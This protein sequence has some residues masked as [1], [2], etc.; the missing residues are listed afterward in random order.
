MRAPR[1]LLRPLASAVLGLGLGLGLLGPVSAHAGGSVDLIINQPSGVLKDHCVTE[2]CKAALKVIEGAKETLD[3]AIYGLRNQTAL[4]QAILDAKERGVRVRLIVDKDLENQNYYTSTPELEAALGDNAH[5][6]YDTDKRTASTRK[7]YDPRTARCDNPPGFEGPAQC[8]GFD[9]GETCLVGVH[10]SRGSLDFKGDIMHHKFMV[11]DRRVV[12]MGSTN[13]SDSGTGGYNANLVAVIDHPDV[14]RWYT[15]EFEQMFT[16]KRYHNEKRSSGERKHVRIDE[17]TSLEVYFSPQDEPMERAVRPLLQN[18]RE[19]ID[20]AVFFLTHKGVAADLIAAHR[21]GVKVRVILD[22]T[23]AKNGY[24]KHEIL[25]AAGIPLKIETWGG[26]MHM[27]SAVID[28]EHVIVGSMNWTSAGTRSNDE[29]TIVL[30]SKKLA[31]EYDQGFEKLWEAIDDRWLEGRPDPESMDSPQAC[32]DGVDNDYDHHAD[33][34]DPGC[35]PN[36]PPL[37]A[38]PPHRIVPKEEGHGLIKGVVLEDGRKM[39]Y[40]PNSR[41]YS[42]TQVDES[43]GGRWFCSEGEAWDAG[44][45]RSRQ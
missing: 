24:T 13:L 43:Q 40:N 3:I 38:L 35:G 36:P 29:N 31:R 23:A 7:P 21:R 6:D 30:H 12:W 39:F 27:K 15:A 8:L 10:A 17:D 33:S 18:A 16:D 34:E 44:Y 32:R 14:G 5:D 11:A 45:R 19:Q 37:P 20:V 4:Q 41:Y 2:H 25:R 26:K 28:H 42:R 1:P 9:L 22:A